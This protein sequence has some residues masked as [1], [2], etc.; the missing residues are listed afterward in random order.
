MNKRRVLVIAEAAN[1]EWVSVPLVGWS[2]SAALR[3]VA[4]VHV[5]TQIRNREAILRAGWVEGTDFTAIDTE[6]LAG[7]AYRLGELLRGGAGKG[8][9]TVQAIN[10]LAYPYFEWKIWQH[11]KA[12]LKAG[13]F[14]VVHRVTP[15]SPI[16]PSLLARRLKEI[17]VPFM[18]GP[19]NGGVPWPKEFDSERR[20]EREW[21]SYLRHLHSW[22]PGRT[23]TFRHS[24]AILV[25]SRHT[26]SEVPAEYHAKTHY[27]AENAI[28]PT[29]FFGTAPVWDGIGPLHCV[30]VGRLVPYKGADMLVEALEPYLISGRATLS[31]VG[32]GPEKPVLDHMATRIQE[33][34]PGRAPPVRMLGWLEHAMVQDILKQ[35]HLF[36]FPSIREFGGGVVLEAMAVGLPPLVVDYAGPGELVTPETGFK[37]PVG[38]K[39]AIIA[40]MRQQIE[41]ILAD[42]A[43]LAARSKQA[44]LRVNALF[45]WSAKAQQID[46][47]YRTISA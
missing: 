41:A 22:I 39:A 46:K 47:I 21:L 45:S 25:G 5:C 17:G 24:A 10:M 9:T 26:E 42:P 34:V 35:S 14:D 33:L 16:V 36:T 30:F 20:R 19:L 32:D 1:P 3:E 15:L 27:I 11:F 29:R 43:G 28:D 2:L 8:W 38:T 31:I 44:Q 18:L 23:A 7:P 6:R 4:D 37:V 12:R 40:A 13:E